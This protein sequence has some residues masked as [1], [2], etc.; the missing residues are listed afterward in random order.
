MGKSNGFIQIIIVEILGQGP[1][2]L[3]LLVATVFIHIVTVQNH[4]EIMLNLVILRYLE[5]L[6]IN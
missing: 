1:T 2:K 3:A 6:S 5:D 4:V